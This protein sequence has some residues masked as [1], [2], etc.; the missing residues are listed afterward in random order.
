MIT[1]TFIYPVFSEHLLNKFGLSTE[2]SSIF[3]VISMFSYFLTLQFLNKISGKI[4]VKL[5]ICI[6]LVLNFL[7]VPLLSPV[8]FLPQSLVTIIIGLIILGMTGACVTVPGIVDFMDTMKNKLDLDDLAANDVSSALYNLSINTG[9]AIGPIVGG[10]LTY[11]H[12]FDTACYFI[13]FLCLAYATL[14][15]FYNLNIIKAQ[16]V[17][18]QQVEETHDEDYKEIKKQLGVRGESFETFSF[19]TRYRASSFSH[20]VG[21]KRPSMSYTE[22]K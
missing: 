15:G 21:S 17:K 1:T 14:F 5:T 6:G 13:S 12:S 20:H 2:T 9:E 8:S 4:G 22:F 10:S 18:H 7:I 19:V 11:L 16:F 3:F